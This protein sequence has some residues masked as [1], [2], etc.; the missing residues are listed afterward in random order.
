MTGA[1]ARAPRRATGKVSKKLA[2]TAMK[3]VGVTGDDSH[4]RC[5]PCDDTLRCRSRDVYRALL[6]TFCAS[7]ARWYAG[8]ASARAT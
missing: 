4:Q 1:H 3:K 2:L 8:R 7:N 6:N 5:T